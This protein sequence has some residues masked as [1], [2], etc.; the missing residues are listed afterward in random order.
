MFLKI[1]Q[2]DLMKWALRAGIMLSDGSIRM[3]GKNALMS[4]QQTHIE[5]T[6]EVWQRCFKLKLILS[7]IHIINRKNKKTVY[8]FQTLTLPYFTSLFNDWYKLIEARSA[9]IK[10]YL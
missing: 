9:V 3:N 4:I 2:I 10:F 8:S 1:F 6:Q 7:G 5:L